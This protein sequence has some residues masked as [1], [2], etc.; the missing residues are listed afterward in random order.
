MRILLI[1]F[2]LTIAVDCGGNTSPVAI[3]KIAQA[4]ARTVRDMDGKYIFSAG[5]NDIDSY[6]LHRKEKIE[7]REF[8]LRRLRELNRHDEENFRVVTK[9]QSIQIA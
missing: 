7:D 9:Y 5:V 3:M 1:A 8:K 6:N 4:E 2:L